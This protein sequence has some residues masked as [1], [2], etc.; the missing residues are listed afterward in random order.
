[1][2]TVVRPAYE[3]NVPVRSR[4]VAAGPAL[5]P[6]GLAVEGDN[7]VLEAVKW[8]EAGEALILR[9]YDAGKQA[10]Q[11]CVTLPAAVRRVALANML[12]EPQAEL[13]W[14][15]GHCVRFPVGPLQIVTL[16]CEV[17]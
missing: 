13:T 15:D 10:S 12:E 16:R 4:V 14:E 5:P 6:A 8:A 9:L 11:A 7:L 2:P 3:L 17:G 1:M